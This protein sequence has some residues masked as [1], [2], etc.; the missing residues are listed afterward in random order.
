VGKVAAQLEAEP[1]SPNVQLWDDLDA[2]DFDDPVMVSKY[3]ADVC[4]YLK[5]LEVHALRHSITL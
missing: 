4:V 5:E 2:E 1:L 3:V